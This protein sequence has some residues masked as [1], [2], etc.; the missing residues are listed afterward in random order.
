MNFKLVISAFLFLVSFSAFSSDSL[1][2]KMSKINDHLWVHTTYSNFNGS[3]VP[4]NGLVIKTSE[5]A[6]I[7]DTGWDDPQ[8]EQLLQWIKD[9][10]GTKVLFCI[11]SHA[12]AD[13]IGGIKALYKNNIKALS[14]SRTAARALA[15][16]YPST[17]PVL[18]DDTILKAGKTSIQTY[19]PGE[20]HTEDNI[21][22]YLPKDKIL[23]GGCFI[24]SCDSK[25]LGFVGDANLDKWDDSAMKL[26][27][28]FPS[29]KTVIPGHYGWSCE[30][31]IDHT[32]K[33]MK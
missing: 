4:S 15:L 5:G 13:R 25:D 27:K 3:M 7:V 1:K 12:H 31:A 21:V 23:F 8:T 28:K 22:I 6:V 10:L 9:S 24:K 20:G 18:P 32:I 30:E 33:L 11:V 19:Y 29:L 17:S 14:T 26:K 2:L 16:G